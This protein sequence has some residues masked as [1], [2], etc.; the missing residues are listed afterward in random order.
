MST[1]AS[2]RH[3]ANLAAVGL[4]LLLFTNLTFGAQQLSFTMD[5]PSHIARGYI[6][7]SRWTEGFWYFSVRGSHPPLI[8]IAE[9]FLLFIAQPHLPLETLSGWGN[10]FNTFATSFLPYLLPIER[11]EVLAR[12]PVMLL[13]VL[14]GAL[15]FRWGKEIKNGWGGLAALALLAFDPL[16]LAHGRL[17]TNDMGVTTF[18]ALALFAGWRWTQRPAWKWALATGGLMGL[19]LLSKFSGVLWGAAFGLIA[20]LVILWR[21]RREGPLRV[22]QVIA[23]GGITLLILWATFGFSFGRPDWLPVPLPAPTYWTALRYQAGTAEDRIFIAFNQIWYGPQWW[24]FP[25]NVIIKD[26]LPLLAAWTISV[27]ILLRRKLSPGLIA[28]T[29]FPGLYSLVAI[30]GGMN[31]SYRHLMPVHP[32]L[33]LLAGVGIV[34]WLASRV[35]P[36]WVYAALGL[37]GAWYVLGTVRLFPDEIAFF[38]E[39]VGGPAGGH[40][41]LVDYTQ[42]WGQSFKELRAYLDAQPG[43]V[44]Q[45]AHFTRVDPGFY[46]VTFLRPSEAPKRTPLRPKPGRYIVGLPN[47]YGLVGRDPSQFEWFR[48]AEPTAMIGHALLVYDVTDDP[49]WLLQCNSPGVPLDDEAFER[50]LGRPDMRQIEFNCASAWLYPAGGATLGI[51]ALH[52]NLLAQAGPCLFAFQKCTPV[53]T[54]PFIARQ[55]AQMRLSY[56][57]PAASVMPALALYENR[58]PLR[59]PRL[60]PAQAAPA[61]AQPATL[62]T[63]LQS[64]IALEG[65]LS[66]RGAM[67]Y[68]DKDGLDVETWWQVTQPTGR[69]FSIMAHLLNS[70][71]ES[72]GV[73]DGLGISP[74][75]LAAGD[76]LVQRHHFDRPPQTET[77]WLRTG[78]YWLDVE[79]NGLWNVT[80]V[81]GAD[82]LFIR[83]GR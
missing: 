62:N 1:S 79:S 53:A 59:W 21:W 49:A 37:L 70:R 24:Y 45:V 7:L 30:T 51:Y 38:N 71:G 42:D 35:R 15:V 13:A 29:A 33:H 2:I 72:L 22:I 64:N 32:F 55:L 56:E 26:P 17:A 82:A 48:R 12:T 75:A 61:N 23:A 50:G 57:Q 83:L 20:S 69:L 3:T 76:V 28:L 46:G 77:L 58:P 65:P 41:Y 52:H 18:G 73:A 9:G 43:P 34:T 11:T 47:L 10:D 80:G 44:P 5:E 16:I 4:L 8:N 67:V 66:F 27:P 63:S 68:R 78:A 54:E 6:F 40:R 31:I 14:L 25:F 19:T 60:L 36:R 39:L 74:D 81:T